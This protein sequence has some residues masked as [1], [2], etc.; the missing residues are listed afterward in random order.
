MQ[1]RVPIQAMHPAPRVSATTSRGYR[2]TNQGGYWNPSDPCR[3]AA[4]NS[5]LHTKLK[6][7]SHLSLGM[8]RKP[9]LVAKHGRRDSRFPQQLTSAGQ[10][11]AVLVAF[12][13][14]IER[15]QGLGRGL[16]AQSANGEEDH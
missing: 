6:S 16:V 9:L 2:G 15:C 11:L 13:E 5:A 7:R 14:T 8:E 12:D 1:G 3:S 10:A 4:A